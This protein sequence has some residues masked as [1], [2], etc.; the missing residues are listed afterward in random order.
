VA[1]FFFFFFQLVVALV[2]PSWEIERL[3]NFFMAFFQGYQSKLRGQCGWR[4]N[5]FLQTHIPSYWSGRV[6]LT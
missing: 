6:W 2:V 1:F 4:L 5:I 3:L